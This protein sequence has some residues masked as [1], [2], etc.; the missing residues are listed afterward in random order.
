MAKFNVY[1]SALFIASKIWWDIYKSF[2]LSIF[3]NLKSV[4]ASIKHDLKHIP[5]CKIF[6][7]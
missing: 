1:D 2:I 4:R 5:S 7:A 3:I 6:L